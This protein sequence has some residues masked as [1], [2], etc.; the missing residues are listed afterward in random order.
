MKNDVGKIPEFFRGDT[1]SP[2][3]V[4]INDQPLIAYPWEVTKTPKKRHNF[5]GEKIV[6]IR[7]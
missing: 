4:M 7:R 3:K 6:Q 5:T 1:H 2:K